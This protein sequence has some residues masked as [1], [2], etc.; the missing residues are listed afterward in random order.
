MVDF[1]IGY[2]GLFLTSFLAATI[3]PVSSEAFLLGMVLLGYSPMASLLVATAGNTF[4]GW[5][6][7]GIGRMGNP[8]W[9]KRTGMSIEVIHAW[10]GRVEKYTYWLA[11][12]CWL[13]FI[14]DLIGIALGFFRAKILPSFLFIL[15]GK[16]LRYLL[17][18]L[19][20]DYL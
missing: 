17:I 10:K 12:F 19:L 5:L 9:L 11:F 4:G 1:E 2:L 3:I 13:P 20:C 14:G 7:Y 15:I 8:R 18:I 6:N 16:F